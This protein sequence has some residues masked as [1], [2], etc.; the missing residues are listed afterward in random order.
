MYVVKNFE[1]REQTDDS[2][3]IIENARSRVRQQWGQFDLS[4][5]K[6][7]HRYLS[8]SFKACYSRGKYVISSSASFFSTITRTQ[9]LVNSSI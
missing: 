1:K 5:R 2:L 9:I 7:S 8:Y 3:H 6:K 4:Q